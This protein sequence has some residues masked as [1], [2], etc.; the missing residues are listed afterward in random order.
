MQNVFMQT[1][2]YPTTQA[3]PAA[4]SLMESVREQER[5]DGVRFTWNYWPWTKSD[6]SRTI[7]PLG[8]FLTPF[9]LRANMPAFNYQPIYCH[10]CRAVLNPFCQ[11][12]LHNKTW[13]CC[14]C[15]HRNP[16]PPHYAGVTENE[17]PAEMLPQ[18]ST[19]EYT[20]PQK[21][22]LMPPIFLFVMDTCVDGDDLQCLKDCLLATI[23][24]LPQEVLVGL[25]TFNR[26]VSVH[27]LSMNTIK[28]SFVFRGTKELSAK[29]VQ[30]QLGMG[31]YPIEAYLQSPKTKTRAGN[32]RQPAPPAEP[33]ESCQ[34]RFFQPLSKCSKFLT[35]SINGIS[36]DP[37][38][39]ANGKR[40]L[41]S[42]G[43]AL[44]I[45]TGLLENSYP[46][47]GARI[48]LFAGGPCTHGPGMVVGED[49]KTPIRSYLDIAKGNAPFLGQ[50][51]KFYAN[52]AARAVKHSQ[53][54]D[55][56]AC[57]LDQT[58]L[59]EMRTCCSS[60]GG[61]LLLGDSFNSSL[62]SQ[63]LTMFLS[64]DS[65]SDQL[66]MAFNAEIEV[67]ASR[68]VQVSGCLGQCTSL[69][70]KNEIVSDLDMLGTGGTAEWRCCSLSTGSTLCFIFETTVSQEVSMAPSE[71]LYLQF[72]TSYQH[73]NSQRRV[74]VTTV[75]RSWM[76][77]NNVSLSAGFDQE[78]AAALMARIAV[79]KADLSGGG[80]VQ[81]WIDR[82]LIRL[83]NKFGS[84]SHDEPSSFSL[85]DNFAQLPS[86]V[87][88]LRRSQLLQNSNTSPDE[89]AFYRHCLMRQDVTT[90]LIMIQPV[91]YAYS[92]SGPP[93]PVSLDVSSLQ[94][95]R[96]LLLDTFFH[97]VIYHGETIVQWI[98]AGYDKMPEYGNLA[99]LLEAPIEDA[100]LIY[101]R[102][103]PMPRYVVTEQ[104][105]SQARFLLSKVNPSKAQTG[106]IYGG[107]VGGGGPDLQAAA[108]LTDD[109]SLQ[110]FVDHLRRLVVS[111][112][113][114]S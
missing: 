77:E 80:D 91:L 14:F 114:N 3:A 51:M 95:D 5:C 85:P 33:Q 63:N 68:N 23:A 103:F 47:T 31:S 24:D 11:C 100:Q 92:L 58:G 94:P 112:A 67:K 73:A 110:T 12:D 71:Q 41:R 113:L 25:M 53:T 26:T 61:Q 105:G 45:A 49:L 34:S 72:I 9:K 108:I 37:W 30:D 48:V 20:I 98:S 27:D 82:T 6:T 83:C 89:S 38:V 93:V 101:S 16:F 65:E 97:I 21:T 64:R 54:I 57:A 81:R 10:K 4:V 52:V 109:V 96:I 43:A 29:E 40:N 55:I 2:V 1:N 59:H 111:S 22:A 28:H 36:A 19:M 44:N 76:N 87:Y 18:F 60:T 7:V 15:S 46:G 62:F 75:S 70:V 42:T 66:E 106:V 56:F 69:E 32:R 84:F 78:A 90:S 88:H 17:R 50:A 13:I 102:R 79:T 107:Y 35:D 74:R 86:I 99:H 8:V 104:G 39:T